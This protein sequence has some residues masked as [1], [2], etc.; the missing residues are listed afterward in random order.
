MLTVQGP[1]GK[2]VDVRFDNAAL[3]PSSATGLQAMGIAVNGKPSNVQWITHDGGVTRATV[4]VDLLASGP[5]PAL[6]VQLTSG[7]GASRS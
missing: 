5:R 2:G 3:T 4:S 1:A 7:N 6:I